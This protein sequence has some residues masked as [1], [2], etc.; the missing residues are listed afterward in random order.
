MFE[1]KLKTPSASKGYWE[2][3]K[4]HYDVLEMF[5]KDRDKVGGGKSES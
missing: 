3:V 1:G 4:R 2:E 5:V